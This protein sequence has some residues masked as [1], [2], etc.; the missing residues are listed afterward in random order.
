MPAVGPR[1]RVVLDFRSPVLV[2]RPQF[3]ARRM[4]IDATPLPFATIPTNN[5]PNT[6]WG[7]V[8]HMNNP[9]MILFFM[10]RA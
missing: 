6:N 10:V 8:I 3:L 4:R 5:S 7:M 1:G 2:L 9:E